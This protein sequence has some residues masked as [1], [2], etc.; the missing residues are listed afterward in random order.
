MAQTLG[1]PPVQWLETVLVWLL[2]YLK[3]TG[4]Q[5]G[6]GDKV[7]PERGVYLTIIRNRAH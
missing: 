7:T 4:A 2:I 1:L 5:R 3:L 6:V